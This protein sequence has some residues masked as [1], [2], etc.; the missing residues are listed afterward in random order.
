[1]DG[2]AILMRNQIDEKMK[3]NTRL[4]KNTDYRSVGNVYRMRIQSLIRSFTRPLEESMVSRG[5]Q[6]LT[7]SSTT[8]MY[9][10]SSINN[11]SFLFSISFHRALVK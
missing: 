1:M 10:N 11:T 8:S 9:F 5:R 6:E 4:M 2:D 3:T 7:C